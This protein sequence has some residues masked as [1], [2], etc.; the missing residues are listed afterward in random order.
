M[1]TIFAA[2]V[3]DLFTSKEWYAPLSNTASLVEDLELAFREPPRT[4]FI[5]RFIMVVHFF[6]FGLEVM[7]VPAHCRAALVS[8]LQAT[9]VH[10]LF[11]DR[12]TVTVL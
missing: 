8:S 3:E 9:D 10:L 2:D 4:L 12:K 6:V 1:F 5:V 7:Y 11:H